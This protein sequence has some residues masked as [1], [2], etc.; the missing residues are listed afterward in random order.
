[1]VV[2]ELKRVAEFIIFCTIS[3]NNYYIKVHCVV[4]ENIH[5]HSMEGYWKF[6][7]GGGFQKPK[8]LYESM[9][10]KWNFQRGGG[11]NLKNLPW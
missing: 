10:L 11:F 3:N 1:M 5:A 9:T 6:Q 2:E 4:P 7:G 8:V